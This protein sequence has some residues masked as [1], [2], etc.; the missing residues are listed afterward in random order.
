M[1]HE[2]VKFHWTIICIFDGEQALPGVAQLLNVRGTRTQFWKHWIR[3][4]EAMPNVVQMAVDVQLAAIGQR[5]AGVM[6][7]PA[8]SEAHAI[9]GKIETML[10]PPST[11]AT[12]IVVA[13]D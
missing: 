5:G 13:P 11:R 10:H 7:K 12:F 3:G 2:F 6:R 4:M 8:I 1:A 9:T